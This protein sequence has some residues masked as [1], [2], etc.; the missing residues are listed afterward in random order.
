MANVRKALQEADG[1]EASGTVNNC[2]FC[3]IIRGENTPEHFQVHDKVISF[4]PKN[5]MT[6]GHRL[7]I[8]RVHIQDA[9]ESPFWAGIVIMAAAE[10][11]SRL[12]H[13]FNLITCA[14]EWATQHVMHLHVHY[15]P[16]KPNDHLRLPW[17]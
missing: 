13:E 16:R 15:V 5:P 2:N 8:P 9:A 14:G 4:K 12:R 11:A 7:F 1:R 17:D 3:R 10:Y 6:P